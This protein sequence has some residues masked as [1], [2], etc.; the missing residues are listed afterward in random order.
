MEL[1]PEK[2]AAA[3]LYAEEAMPSLQH[4]G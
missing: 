2:F 1:K 3:N 4:R